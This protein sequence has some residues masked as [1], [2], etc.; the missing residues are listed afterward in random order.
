MTVEEKR[1]YCTLCRSRC[2]TI[3]RVD[4]DSLIKVMPDTEHPTGE[5]MCMKGRAA[6]ELVHNP[7]RI[8]HPMRRTTPKTATD[9][10]WERISWQEAIATIAARLSD[11]KTESGAES[12]AFGVTTPSGTPMSDSI[13]WVERFV[14]AFQSPNICYGTEVCNWHKDFA[15]AFTFGCGMPAADYANADLIM[16]WGHN[17][18][19][20]WLSQANAI[21][22][23]RKK[24]ARMIVV[25]PRKTPLAASADAWLRVRPGTDIVVALGLIRLLIKYK[26]FNDHF[27]RAWTNAPFLVRS[28]DGTLLRPEDC[29]F[30]QGLGDETAP[31]SFVVWDSES[32]A[33]AYYAPASG[34]SL[35]HSV[36]AALS[37]RFQVTLRNG[38]EVTCEPV[39][40][41]LERACAPYSPDVV[42]RISGVDTL[43][44]DR[45]AELLT[46]NKRV[47]YH[48]WTGIGQHSNATQTER[49]VAIL[50]ALTGSFD[51]YGGNR[52]YTQ[53]PV[54]PLNGWDLIE[55][56]QLRKALGVDQ[57]PLGPP[58]QG[59]VTARDLYRGIVDGQ[60]YRIRAFVGFGTNT[61]ISQGDV[62]Q[63]MEALR[64]L[65]FHVHCDLF[66][67]PSSR[68]ADIFLPVNTPWEREALRAGF[69]INEAAV[70]HIQLRQR[71]VSPRGESRSDTEIVFALAEALGMGE[72]F[73][74]GSIEAGWN[75]L[76][77]PL[78]LTVEQLRQKPEGLRHKLMQTPLKY[79]AI[80][81]G[82][83][84]GFATPTRRVELYSEM[85]LRH[86]YYPLPNA[87][88]LLVSKEASLRFPYTLTSVKNGYFCHSQH[89]S[90]VSLRK[91]SPLPVVQ[92]SAELGALKGIKDGDWVLIET[93]EGRARFCASLSQDLDERVIVAEFGWWQACDELGRGGYAVVGDGNSNYNALISARHSDPISGSV[94]MRAFHC[95]IQRDPAQDIRRRTWEGFR[96]FQVRTIRRETEDVATI[97]LVTPDGSLLPDY[98]PGQH[99]T[100]SVDKGTDD[101]QLVRAYSLTGPAQERDRTSYC[102]AVRHQRGVDEHGNPVEGRMSGYLHRL[103]KPG[104]E[105]HL[106][107]PGGNFVL[108][109]SLPQP[110]VIF[111]GGIGITPFIS[112]LETLAR[113]DSMPE[114]WLHYSNRNSLSHA[115][116]QR[117][118]E[119]KSRL[120]RLT[121]VNYYNDPLATDVKGI[122]YDFD[123]LVSAA[124]VPDSLIE[125]RAR[126]YLCGPGPMMAAITNQLVERGVLEFDIFSELFRSPATLDPKGDQHYCVS[127]Q[128]S[129][130]L[131]LD[132][133]PASGPLLNFAEKQGITLPSG[134]R[135]GQCESCAVR[136]V[137]GQ[138]YH[139]N[140]QEPED[141][142]VCLTC[143]AVPVSDL[144]LD[145]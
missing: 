43:A 17:P 26:G 136:I 45:A 22:K 48:A 142:N 78:G 130:P 77:E 61:L 32:V 112:Y 106:G 59:W 144:E 96:P 34:S 12:V 110:V 53:L 57:R 29:A 116:A 47:A 3:S 21:G 109:V 5:A 19:N 145:I 58:A 41:L 42:E 120:P 127:F 134:C 16:L 115:F 63:G 131:G 129:H 33:P 125:R 76:L 114:V 108:P 89:R 132:W 46:A 88:K 103:L 71:A 138:V 54:R 18:T 90:L 143:Q 133:S 117:I 64:Q 74:Q 107:A 31:E 70:E 23:G 104:Q 98:L 87:D 80:S 121:V 9:P 119:L 62:E 86:G 73:F 14:R 28:D 60:P 65:E 124:V 111:A 37:G 38:D 141:P 102:I 67:T 20:T 122:D 50:Y 140:G 105:V 4:G 113:S 11:I 10:G 95:D 82:K 55:P 91:R 8:L 99:I 30:A 40:A 72:H 97:E 100:L 24:G 92:L 39:F 83:I 36:H 85:L 128:R 1:G 135:V 81:N 94:P 6:P 66:E 52:V 13:D 126:V 27:V 25:D 139:L 2:G 15:H 93:T 137:S 51:A 101:P 118:A 7:N 56:A 75:W 84:Q 123:T 69:E 68:S 49:A 44:L 79:T 35:A